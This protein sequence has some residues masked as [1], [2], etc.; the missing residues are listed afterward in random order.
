MPK[1]YIKRRIAGLLLIA[2]AGMLL[3]LKWTPEC[4]T[5]HTLS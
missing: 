3:A 2:I 5:K 4:S 1:A